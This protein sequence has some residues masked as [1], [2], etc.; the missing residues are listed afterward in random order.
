[1]NCVWCAIRQPVVSFHLF[2]LSPVMYTVYNSTVLLLQQF[3]ISTWQ[4]FIGS[5]QIKY[6]YQSKITLNVQEVFK[7]TE[8]IKDFIHITLRASYACDWATM[9]ANQT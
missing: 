2:I 1:M 7:K 6:Y 8:I 9:N 5:I 3:C 4:V